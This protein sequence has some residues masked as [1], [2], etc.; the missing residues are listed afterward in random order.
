MNKTV[1]LEVANDVLASLPIM[2][3]LVGK[4]GYVD[5]TVSELPQDV[6]DLDS[7]AQASLL[8]GYCSVCA[9]GAC[10]LSFVSLHNDYT[11]ERSSSC[12]NQIRPL[13]GFTIYSKLASVF[14]KLQLSMIESAFEGGKKT[15]QLTKEEVNEFDCSLENSVNYYKLNM[16]TSVFG[17]LNRTSL[18]QKIMQN[19]IDNDGVF[20]PT[21]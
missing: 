8:K 15:Y 5:P 21:K 10:F 17:R 4:G 1:I 13:N 6:W 16:D 2:A 18:L 9:L 14:S 3:E 20:D 7:R 19:I 12:I 11:F